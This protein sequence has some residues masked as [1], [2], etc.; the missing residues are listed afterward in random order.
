MNAIGFIYLTTNLV[1]GKIYVG[2]HE[3]NRENKKYLGSGY[4]FRIALNKYGRENFKRKILRIC[5]SEHELTI[6]E[7]IYIKKY[8]SQDRN[9]GYNIASGNVNTSEYNPAKLPEVRK[10]M[11]VAAKK[12]LSNPENH[13]LWGK[14]FSEESRR[15]M[16]ENH[17]DVSGKNNPMYGKHHTEETRRK[18]SESGKKKIFTEEHKKH[19]SEGQRRRLSRGKRFWIN[20]GIIEKYDVFINDELPEGFVIGKIKK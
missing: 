8:H 14:H 5:Y 18:M 10:K 2:R 1:N 16:S 11:S 17:A 4:K 3:F 9:I 13:N 12:R 19:L 6:W 15:K 7:Y 20:N